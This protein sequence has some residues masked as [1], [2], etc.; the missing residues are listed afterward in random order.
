MADLA[1][2]FHWPPGELLAMS[3]DDLLAWHRQA[4]RINKLKNEEPPK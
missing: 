3:V 1:A 2:T 4:I